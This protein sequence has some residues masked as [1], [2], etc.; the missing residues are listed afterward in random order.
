MDKLKILDKENVENKA[1]TVNEVSTIREKLGTQHKR[2]ST[3]RAR[4]YPL[5]AS[6]CKDANSC[7]E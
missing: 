5:K 1:I 2:N 3:L 6:T 7:E 4:P